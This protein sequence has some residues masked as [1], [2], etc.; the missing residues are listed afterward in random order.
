MLKESTF[1]SLQSSQA[2]FLEVPTIVFRVQSYVLPT[3]LVTNPINLALEALPLFG[4]HLPP[5]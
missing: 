5:P 3:W 2:E 4:L 1:G